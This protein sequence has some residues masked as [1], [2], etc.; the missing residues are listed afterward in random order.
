[1]LMVC[2]FHQILAAK[3][4]LTLNVCLGELELG[5]GVIEL[6]VRFFSTA[7]NLALHSK[8]TMQP[9][10][11]NQNRFKYFSQTFLNVARKTNKNNIKIQY[12]IKQK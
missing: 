2:K 11:I 3:K 1:M 8:Q 6:S 7:P 9:T 4:L 12:K 10:Q 5:R